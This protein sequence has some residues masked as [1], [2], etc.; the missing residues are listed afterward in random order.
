MKWPLAL[1]LL[2]V[3]GSGSLPGMP[4]APAQAQESRVDPMPAD[5]VPLEEEIKIFDGKTPNAIE[6]ARGSAVAVG[7]G[8]L[9]SSTSIALRTF[10]NRPEGGLPRSKII[11]LRTVVELP[12]SQLDLSNPMTKSLFIYAPAFKGAYESADHPV[13]EVAISLNG[14]KE[15][16]FL[17]SYIPDFP[18]I[19]TPAILEVVI[20]RFPF[21]SPFRRGTLRVSVQPIDA[22]GVLPGSPTS[23]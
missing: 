17:D 23:K 2:L 14:G 22:G 15:Y 16:V 11:G 10:E 13:Q 20:G 6:L 1:A 19:I 7:T 8:S 5:N 18:V 4:E 12:F 21:R 9:K 3:C